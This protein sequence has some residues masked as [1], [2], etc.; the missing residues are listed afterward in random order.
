MCVQIYKFFAKKFKIINVVKKLVNISIK[1]LY[2][3]S[4]IIEYTKR[5]NVQQIEVVP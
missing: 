1:Y 2:N 3:K 4:K 5:I